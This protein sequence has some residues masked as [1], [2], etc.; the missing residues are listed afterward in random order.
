MTQKNIHNGKNAQNDSRCFKQSTE[1]GDSWPERT[2]SCLHLA[3][4]QKLNGVLL[5]VFQS[6]LPNM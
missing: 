2:V 6:L 5:S 4:N 3:S 1:Y